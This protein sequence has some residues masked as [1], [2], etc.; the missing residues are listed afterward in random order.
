[1]VE[2]A[3]NSAE[4]EQARI[5][6]QVAA[7]AYNQASVELEQA[8]SDADEAAAAAEQADA[9]VVAAQQ[10]VAQIAMASYR[11]NGEV[12]QLS[13]FFSADDFEQALD[14]ATMFQVIGSDADDAYQ[15]LDAAERVA[16]VMHQRADEALGDAETAAAAREEASRDAD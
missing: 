5:D 16:E 4:L 11:S 7:E 15:R 3:A 10:Q 9:D 12:Q 1:E 8:Q 2:L 13:M 14:R 6:A